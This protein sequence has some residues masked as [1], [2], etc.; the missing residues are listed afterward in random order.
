MKKEMPSGNGELLV[1]VLGG[2]SGVGRLI[3]GKLGDV[4]CVNRVRFQQVAFMIYGV[5]TIVLPFLKS[6]EGKSNFHS[7]TLDL[8][9]TLPPRLTCG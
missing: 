8:T 6:F 1:M 7:L 2:V 4:E 5:T 3:S 9:H